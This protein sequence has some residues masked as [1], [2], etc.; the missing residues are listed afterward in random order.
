MDS[1]VLGGNDGRCFFSREGNEISMRDGVFFS[2]GHGDPKRV[3]RFDRISEILSSHISI[4]DFFRFFNKSNMGKTGSSDALSRFF[5]LGGGT[6]LRRRLRW[7]FKSLVELIVAL[8]M[9]VLWCDERHVCRS[10]LERLRCAGS[11]L[12]KAKFQSLIPRGKVSDENRST[13]KV[14]SAVTTFAVAL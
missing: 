6:F 11:F 7:G 10:A 14:S 2:V 13:S 12:R 5:G 1:V 3:V 4:K 8:V 9:L